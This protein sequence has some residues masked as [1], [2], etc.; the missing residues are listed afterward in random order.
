MQ[1]SPHILISKNIK[2][3]FEK[4]EEIVSSAKA[5]GFRFAPPGEIDNEKI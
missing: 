1:D 4:E 3:S 5:E 2:K